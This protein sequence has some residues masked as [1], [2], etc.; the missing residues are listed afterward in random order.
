MNNREENKEVSKTASFEAQDILALV[1]G[2]PLPTTIKKNLWKSLGRLVTGLV[3]IPVAYLEAK[4]ESIKGETVALN[5]FRNRVAEKASVD[6]T[7]DS[8]LM[9]RAVNYYGSKLLKEQLNRE[10]VVDKTAEELKLNPPTEDTN[11]EIDDDWL[12]MF[13]KISES[14][15]NED[16]QLILSKILAGEIK[17]PGSFGARS[18][19]TLILLDQET[20]LIF[21]K[22]CS[23]SYESAQFGETH[24]IC[25]PFGSPG[26]N[27]LKEFGLNYVS[28]TQLQDAGLIQNSLTF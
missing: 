25:E 6:F 23:I 28:L 10:S 7:N 26:N 16:I 11:K 14:K 9:E 24:L 5:L 4:S 1:D 3:D 2:I 12:E 22:F 8:A 20:A 15:S 17:K 19:Q 13:S 21:R 27:G 18:L